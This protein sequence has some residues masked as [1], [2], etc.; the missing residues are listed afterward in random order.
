M[1]RSGLEPFPLA[2][3]IANEYLGLD[4][5]SDHVSSIVFPIGEGLFVWQQSFDRSLSA[6]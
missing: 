2:A 6:E 1:T 3:F 4:G 5:W